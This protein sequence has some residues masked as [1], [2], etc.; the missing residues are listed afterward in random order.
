M[1]EILTV[2]ELL[3]RGLQ[4]D[5][6]GDA[7]PERYPYLA[8]KARQ[9]NAKARIRWRRAV[10]ISREGRWASVAHCNQ[11]SSGNWLTAQTLSGSS[12]LCLRFSA[13]TATAW[14]GR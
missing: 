6:N 10:W 3:A 8:T 13:R 2:G 5:A 14:P 12:N 1:I 7:P 4:D 11:S 9:Y